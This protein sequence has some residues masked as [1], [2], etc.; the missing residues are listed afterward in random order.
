[1]DSVPHFNHTLICRWTIKA[2]VTAKSE[3]RNWAKN[4]RSGS[5][6]NVTFLDES[7]NQAM[8]SLHI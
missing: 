4:G 3:I 8:G 5:L 6:F 2:R 1:M 7:V